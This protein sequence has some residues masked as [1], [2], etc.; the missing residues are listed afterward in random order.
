MERIAASQMDNCSPLLVVIMKICACAVV[1]TGGS[2]RGGNCD[3]RDLVATQLIKMSTLREVLKR[4]HNKLDVRH[5]VAENKPKPDKKKNKSGSSSIP[6]DDEH[7]LNAVDELV[8]RNFFCVTGYEKVPVAT[9]KGARRG[10]VGSA[11]ALL[12]F[13][14]V[15]RT[16]RTRIS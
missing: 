11:I 15:L 2:R 9:G 5:C 14:C 16:L 12:T 7:I 3:D 4:L 6:E 10:S 1:G 8:R 13:I